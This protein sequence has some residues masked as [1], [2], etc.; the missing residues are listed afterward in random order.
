MDRRTIFAVGIPVF[1]FAVIIVCEWGGAWHGVKVTMAENK[2]IA[3]KLLEDNEMPVHIF[4]VHT[5]IDYAK[6]SW[7]WTCA[8]GR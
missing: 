7:L 4:I 1:I 8:S 5:V 6:H 2:V 3:A